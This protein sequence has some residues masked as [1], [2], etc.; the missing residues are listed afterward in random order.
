MSLCISRIFLLLLFSLSACEQVIDNPELPY[1]NQLV[2][3]G[4]VNADSS[5]QRVTV[6]HTLP[7]TQDFI[8]DSSIVRN[9]KVVL[10]A[11]GFD[12]LMRFNAIEQCY[13]I[14]LRVKEGE[15][16]RLTVEWEG[17]KAEASTQVPS[18]PVIS[19][20][21][22]VQLRDPLADSMFYYENIYD[23]VRAQWESS[24]AIGF[25]QSL[26][27]DHPADTSMF[28]LEPDYSYNISPFRY[29]S[30]KQ[31][32]ATP[33]LVS[34][35][36]SSQFQKYNYHATKLQC[37]DRRLLNVQA[38]MYS[39]RDEIFGTF[40]VSPNANVSGQGFGYFLGLSRTSEWLISTIHR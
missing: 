37:V 5:V 35:R 4:Y 33:T 28:E 15:K 20:Y 23:T 14:A 25:L 10:H 39:D 34:S 18:S 30:D 12:S 16:Y 3:G 13:V 9:A 6:C 24:A 21:G 7:L 40:G 1:V 17:L 29:L 36:G 22:C 11:P 19:S 32:G 27:I 8:Y 2:I 38:G 26:N 31:S